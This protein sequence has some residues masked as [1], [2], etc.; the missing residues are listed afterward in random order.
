MRHAIKTT[1]LAGSLLATLGFLAMAADDKASARREDQ[2]TLK[3]YGELVGSWRGIG[4]AKAR[5]S[6]GAWKETASW[7][8]KLADESAALEVDIET[9]KYLKSA[10][11]RP[12]KGKSSGAFVL[13][14]TLAD[15][16]K[17]TFSGK[18]PKEKDRPLVLNAEGAG[19]GVRRVTLS[20]PNENRFLILLESEPAS[21]TFARL[22]EVGFTRNGVAFAAGESGPTCIVTEGRGT[23]QV[24]HKGKSYY[25]CCSGCKDL[26]NKDPEAI[27]AEAAERAKAKEKK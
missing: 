5:Q 17:R 12:G 8:W 3:A 18:A 9:G 4:Q 6:A 15:G 26:F 16:S 13:E 23:I 14:A 7:A 11:L 2:E 22:G 25:V 27:L 20:I 19:E 10:L 24:S 1:I 21:K